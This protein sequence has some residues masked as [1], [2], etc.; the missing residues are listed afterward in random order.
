MRWLLTQNPN[1]FAHP[2]P[3]EAAF[4][5]LSPATN[6]TLSSLGPSMP[7]TSKPQAALAPMLEVLHAL[8]ATIPPKMLH[9]YVLMHIPGCPPDT[10]T[11]LASFFTTLKPPPLLR[12]VWCHTNYTEIENRDRMM[13]RV[14]RS[15]GLAAAMATATARCSGTLGLLWQDS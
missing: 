13:M 1:S 5:G 12:C 15:S 14:L 7:D 8:V 11:T 6:N 10:L 9:M 4:N 3:L 2:L